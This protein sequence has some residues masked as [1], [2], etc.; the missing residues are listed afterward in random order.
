MKSS[1]NLIL[2]TEIILKIR[3]CS[4]LQTKNS[5]Q[6]RHLKHQPDQIPKRG[7]TQTSDLI[8]PPMLSLQMTENK[9]LLSFAQRLFRLC[10]PSFQINDQENLLRVEKKRPKGKSH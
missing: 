7:H 9:V 10:A 4:S 6:S 3:A 8:F 2:F 1:T 5:F